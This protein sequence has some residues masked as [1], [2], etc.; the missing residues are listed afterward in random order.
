M[1][2]VHIN[3]TSSVDG[4]IIEIH[5]IETSDRIEV[6]AYNKEKEEYLFGFSATIYKPTFLNEEPSFKFSSSVSRT[7]E[8]ALLEARIIGLAAAIYSN[9]SIAKSAY[10]ERGV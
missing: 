1:K 3:E 9:L 2:K 8:G 7:P 4:I 10:V 6:A 5:R